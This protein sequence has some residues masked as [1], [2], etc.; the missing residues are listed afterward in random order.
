M[1]D[2]DGIHFV[3]NRLNPCAYAGFGHCALYLHFIL[4]GMR[5]IWEAWKKFAEIFGYFMSRAVLTVLYYTIL[6]PYGLGV[7]F[8]S[9]PLSIKQKPL[10][11]AWK[12]YPSTDPALEK[13]K[14]QF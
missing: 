3:F 12:P 10:K 8:F 14:Q 5:K 9:D 13:F 1:D 2:S 6:L 11:S 4:I 7:R